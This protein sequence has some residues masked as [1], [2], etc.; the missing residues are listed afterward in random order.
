MFFDVGFL[1]KKGKSGDG[2]SVI[3][4]GQQAVDHKSAK[5]LLATA[6]IAFVS[7]SKAVVMAR[8]KAKRRA[9]EATLTKKRAREPLERVAF[10][11]AKDKEKENEKVKDLTAVLG[12]MSM[13]EQKKKFKGNSAVAAA[14]GT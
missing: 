13:L 3:E 7:M 12:S 1:N 14:I 6:Q 2:E 8:V 4:G 5:V 11:V 10:L 9:K